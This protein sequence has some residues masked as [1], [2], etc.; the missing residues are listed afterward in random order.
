[1]NVENNIPTT[2]NKVKTFKV[3]LVKG[4]ILNFAFTYANF[5]VLYIKNAVK[6]AIAAPSMPYVGISHKLKA[7][8]KKANRTPKNR[9]DL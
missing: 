8:A 5:N 9:I 7:I 3:S 2:T 4:T 6:L 1:M